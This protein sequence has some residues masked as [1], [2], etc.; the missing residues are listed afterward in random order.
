MI[1]RH[2]I[3]HNIIQYLKEKPDFTE[4]TDVLVKKKLASPSNIKRM[5]KVSHYFLVVSISY[6][7]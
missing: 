3:I 1:P 6:S 7:Y 5:K 2:G 4:R